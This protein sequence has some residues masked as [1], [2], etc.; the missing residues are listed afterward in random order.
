MLRLQHLQPAEQQPM[1]GPGRLLRRQLQPEGR[2]RGV[3]R[4]GLQLRP[5]GAVQRQFTALP[6]G[7]RGTLGNALHGDGWHSLHLLW[8]GLLAE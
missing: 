6:G 2:R 8:E 5:A 7:R 4:G 1:L 3:P